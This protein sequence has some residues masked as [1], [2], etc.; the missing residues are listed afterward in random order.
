MT[1][2]VIFTSAG[3]IQFGY[4]TSYN[5]GTVTLTNSR[6]CILFTADVGGVGGLAETGPSS[7]CR[8]GATVTGDWTFHDVVSVVVCTAT[9]ETAWVNAP[10]YTG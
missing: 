4:A 3:V 7:S 1:A 9:A 5:E 2:I 8:I 10:T 6:N